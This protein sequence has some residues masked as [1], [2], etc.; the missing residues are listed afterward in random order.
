MPV[1]SAARRV[2]KLF[3]S[4]EYVQVRHAPC[5]VCRVPDSQTI[6]K[7][8]NLYFV[9]ITFRLSRKVFLALLHVSRRSK[10]HYKSDVYSISRLRMVSK[11]LMSRFQEFHSVFICHLVQKGRKENGD[12]VVTKLVIRLS[13]FGPLMLNILSN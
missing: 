12:S 10:C 4:T 5:V 9:A 7:D 3:I 1:L 8:T 11:A 2:M 6:S 13:N